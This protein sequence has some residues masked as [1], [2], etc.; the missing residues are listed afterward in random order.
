MKRPIAPCRECQRRTESC[1]VNCAEWR[2][3][4]EKKA[5]YNELVLNE[6]KK[7][8]GVRVGKGRK[9]WIR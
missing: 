1:R 3:F 2:E 4:E 5:A 9:T 7:S 8:V 6:K